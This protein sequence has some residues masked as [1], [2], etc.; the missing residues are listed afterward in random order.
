MRNPVRLT[1]LSVAYALAPVAPGTAGGAEQVLARLD[2]ELTRAGHKS[3][4]VAS[5]G[6]EVQGTLVAVPRPQGEFDDL[7]RKVAARYQLQA[8][9]HA[10]ENWPVDIVHLHGLD[11][12]DCLPAG[13]VPVLATLHL[14]IAWYPQRV[15]ALAR[16]NTFLNC[17][18]AS[19]HRDCPTC[20]SLLPPIENGVPEEMF[21]AHHAKRQFA[22]TMGRICPEKGFHLALDAAARAGSPLLIAGQVFPYAEHQK[23]FET[24]IVPR[25]D[26]TARFI[27]PVGPPRT[28]RLLAAARCVLIPS[29]ARET[30]SLVAMEA[31][32]CGTPV[33]AY[34]AGALADFVEHGR[35]G[36]LVR[37]T[38][39]MAEAIRCA[40]SI[41]PQ[42]CRQ[43]ARERF[44]IARMTQSYFDIYHRLARRHSEPLH[45][46][47]GIDFRD[48]RID[49]RV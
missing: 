40:D 43:T 44:S 4:V 13:D 12:L 48:V 2:A 17:V 49:Q 28:R 18:S 34:G 41:D 19:Q 33:I 9:Q 11:F 45:Y 29:L 14:P 47:P 36:F 10:L 1:I 6:S 8:I 25:L 27:G 3:L 20:A 5:E 42:V 24:K 22:L 23:Y 21:A 15:F 38:D 26:H 16:P 30:S 46:A 32:A 37:N 7:T 39:E 35:T 31:M